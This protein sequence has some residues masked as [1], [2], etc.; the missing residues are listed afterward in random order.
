MLPSVLSSEIM[1]HSFAL[2]VQRTR[3]SIVATLPL[4]PSKLK[5]YT[6]T[7]LHT[8]NNELIYRAGKGVVCTVHGMQ[9]GKS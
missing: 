1:F 9:H 4:C 6:P 8:T 7:T 5:C 2:R 3:A